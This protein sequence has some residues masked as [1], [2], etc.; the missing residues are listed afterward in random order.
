ME[1]RVDS[2]GNYFE[3]DKMQTT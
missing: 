3:W 2:N 1:Q